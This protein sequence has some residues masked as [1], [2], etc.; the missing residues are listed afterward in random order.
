MSNIQS[1]QFERL[2]PFCD[3]QHHQKLNVRHGHSEVKK[4]W[5]RKKATKCVLCMVQKV[6]KLGPGRLTSH[7]EISWQT[8]AQK[9][10]FCLLWPIFWPWILET[11]TCSYSL[12]SGFRMKSQP[13]WSLPPNA[14]YRLSQNKGILRHAESLLA[15]QF[16]SPIS[17]WNVIGTWW[18]VPEGSPQFS[19]GPCPTHRKSMSGCV[20]LL[21]PGVALGNHETRRRG[22]ECHP[23]P[24][25]FFQKSPP[26]GVN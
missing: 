4:I 13:G 21:W 1:G 22:C 5:G 23:L 24:G 25:L 18:Q 11:D 15:T 8:W 9:Y 16:H 14:Q 7:S 20:L 10:A 19:Q 12:A 26:G 6:G 17:T 3:G 2:G